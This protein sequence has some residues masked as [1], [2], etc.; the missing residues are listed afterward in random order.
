MRRPPTAWR[1]FYGAAEAGF[2]TFRARSST[3]IGGGGGFRLSWLRESAVAWEF[4]L[5]LSFLGESPRSL[6][7]VCGAFGLLLF[8]RVHRKEE[9]RGRRGPCGALVA[10]LG[11]RRE[12]ES[13]IGDWSPKRQRRSRFKT[14]IALFKLEARW[15]AVRR[16]GGFE[17]VKRMCLELVK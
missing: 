17:L 3:L 5:R 13:Q 6:V 14:F 12:L 16:A 7:F 9:R 10:G 15:N 11:L 1:S 4:K 2:G 8:D